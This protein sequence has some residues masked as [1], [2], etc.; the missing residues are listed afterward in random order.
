M[1]TKHIVGK[2]DRDLSKINTRLMEMGKL[3]GK[4]LAD[5]TDVLARADADKI[6]HIVATDQKI[7]GMN[8]TIAN[9]AERLITL[10]QPM[11]LDL[12]AAL[13]A[14]NI[15]SELE[16]I[17]DH[18]KTTARRAG[19]LKHDVMSDKSITLL[20]Q[21]SDILQKQLRDVLQAY[22]TSDE[23]AAADVAKH[24]K[25]IDSLNRDVFKQ[26]VTQLSGAQLAS[27]EDLMSAVIISRN[28]ERVGDHI[29]N[30][31]GH[32]TYIKTGG[33]R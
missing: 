1:V 27:A 10:R 18:A 19:K 17:G 21:M 4:Q 9:R 11:A 13:A 33:V 6:A 15:A 12:R 3:V 28:F 2:F 16:R 25:D 7:N 14:I 31:T 22:Q 30:I 24:D 8:R 23:S 26:T 32:I 29:V 5:A 20:S